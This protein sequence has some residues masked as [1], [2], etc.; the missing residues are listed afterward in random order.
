MLVQMLDGMTYEAV[1]KLHGLGKTAIEKR[2]KT[3]V[4]H[5]IA[6]TGVEG[7]TVDTVLTARRL[8]VSKEAI[9]A[10][11]ARFDPA[12][13]LPA[14]RSPMTLDVL[15]HAVAVT[16]ARSD[17]PNRDIA[18]LLVLF[19]TGAKPIEIA[20][21]EVRD[22]L[23]PDG[24]VR[25]ESVLRAESAVNGRARP[26]FFRAAR[27]CAAIDDYL[28]ERVRRHLGTS[29]AASY[30][31][32]D[33]GSRLFLTEA[34]DPFEIKPRL[35]TGRGRYLCRSIL[36]VYR[37]I[38]RRAG[39]KGV[40]SMTARRTVARRLRERGAEDDQI[41]ELLGV[42]SATTLRELLR[43]CRRPLSAVVEEIV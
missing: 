34:G 1:G 9:L 15:S 2:A 35:K 13:E 39:L 18:L 28:V 36:E 20:R 33:P 19:S 42:K 5:L 41:G 27:A 30:R 23:R 32:L 31:G 22:Y 38:F 17:S 12:R 11:L 10:A 8:R 43:G 14:D 4:E 26:L 3:L 29:G 21:L 40:T 24:S 7:M 37:S 25:E 16:R 6:T